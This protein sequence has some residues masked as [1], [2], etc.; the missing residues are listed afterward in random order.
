LALTEFD[1]SHS[2][3]EGG[4]RKEIMKLR[5]QKRKRNK[6]KCKCNKEDKE[7]WRCRH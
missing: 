7:E 3:P 5:R 6:V 4:K 1:I 2:I